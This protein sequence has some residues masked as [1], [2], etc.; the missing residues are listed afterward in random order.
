M[1]AAAAIFDEEDVDKIFLEGVESGVGEVSDY[2]Y[3][4][5]PDVVALIWIQRPSKKH[6]MVPM[7]RNGKK[8][9]TT[10]S[11]SFKSL[12]PGSW[13]TY[14]LVKQPYHAVKS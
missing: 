11:I 7:P 3:E 4:L 2:L 6:Y 12:E 1:T 14:Q 9:W 10:R 13:R 8:H 5:P